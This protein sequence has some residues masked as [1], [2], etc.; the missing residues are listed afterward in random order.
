MVVPP[1]W[2]PEEFHTEQRRQ[3]RAERNVLGERR[4]S[5]GLIAGGALVVALQLPWVLIGLPGLGIITMPIG[6]FM[7]IGG[8]IQL[9]LE[10][11]E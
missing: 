6:L 3:A 8:G 1:Q 4:R 10:R 5:I 11:G 7:M 9:L 2:Q